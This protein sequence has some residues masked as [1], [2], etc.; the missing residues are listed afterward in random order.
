MN[1]HKSEARKAAVARRKAAHG[2]GLDAAAQAALREVLQPF[3]GRVLAGYMPIRTE[4]DPLPAMHGWDAVVGVPVIVGK[5]QPLAFYRWRPGCAMV[6]G[7]FGARVPAEAEPVVPQV[8]IV[9]L[10][11]FDGR[12]FRLGY[13]GGF[14][15]RTLELLRAARDTVAIGYAFAA[16]ETG[17]V[18]LEPTDQRLDMIV[19]EQGV[20]RFPG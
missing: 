2:Q 1:L 20:R 15:D 5:G 8:L 9:P 6:E 14:Y 3:P 17:A 13:G 16:Q 10:V 4:I 11:A 19:T 7:P 18:P 12:G